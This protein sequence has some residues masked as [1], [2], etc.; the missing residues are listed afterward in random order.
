M[1]ATSLHIGLDSYD[2]NNYPQARALNSSTL[3]ASSMYKLARQWGYTLLDGSPLP[4]WTTFRVPPNVFLDSDATS[5]NVRNAIAEV[6]QKL[7]RGDVF[8]LTFSGHGARLP[9][10]DGDETDH[11]DEA[12]CL[13]DHLLIDDSIKCMLSK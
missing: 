1:R 5:E 7:Q 4:A 13:Y 6:S 2:R 10:R 3:D 8:F 11:R 12:V 9:D